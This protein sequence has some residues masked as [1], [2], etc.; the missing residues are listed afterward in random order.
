MANES[1]T[2]L[3][4]Y[5]EYRYEEKRSEFIAEAAPCK[6]EQEALAFIARVKSRFPDAR[7][8]VYAYLLRE[9][10]KN[11][12]SDDHEPQGTAGLPVL[13]VIRKNGC[14]DTVVVVTR[15]FGGVLLGTGGLVRAYTAA[16]VGAL[17]E[18][19]V[20][21]YRI[22]RHLSVALSY[23]DYNKIQ[24]EI[25]SFGAHLVAVDYAEGVELHIS[26]PL[27]DFE[28]YE[29]HIGEVS[30]GRAVIKRLKD[31]FEHGEEHTIV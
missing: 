18:A 28:A 8:H 22:H 11:R 13:D 2:T 21:T 7:H 4:R 27:E 20:V 5:A 31:C 12:Y 16:A 3:A 30:C 19:G 26:I 14:T 23:P 10:A 29:K 25:T 1:Y 15:Y 6:S 17:R 24:Q 9:N